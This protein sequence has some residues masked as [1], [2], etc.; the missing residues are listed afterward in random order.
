MFCVEVEEFGVRSSRQLKDNGSK[1]LVTDANKQ[2]YVH[3]MCQM[4]MTGFFKIFFYFG[5]LICS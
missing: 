1:L 5:T 2:E 3:L 4:K